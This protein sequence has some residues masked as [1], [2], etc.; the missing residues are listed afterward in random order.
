[1]E[2]DHTS[3]YAQAPREPRRAKR[4]V[5]QNYPD[6]VFRVH[7][8]NKHLCNIPVEDQSPYCLYIVVAMSDILSDQIAQAK[9]CSV[10][11]YPNKN[12]FPRSDNFLLEIS[13]LSYPSRFMLWGGFC[14]TQFSSPS[15]VEA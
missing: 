10:S 4:H 15:C 13:R 7:N 1:M 6:D 2:E 3:H 14:Y 12:F 9:V 11:K 8:Q 5:C